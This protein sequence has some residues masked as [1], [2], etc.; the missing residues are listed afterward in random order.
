MTAAGRVGG[1]GGWEG[2]EG[3]GGRCDIYY[4]IAKQHKAE[5]DNLKVSY[6]STTDQNRMERSELHLTICTIIKMGTVWQLHSAL[7]DISLDFT[8]CEL[9]CTEAPKDAAHPALSV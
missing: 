7:H 1:R 5:P 2:G 4:A 6:C 8:P 3:G 9:H